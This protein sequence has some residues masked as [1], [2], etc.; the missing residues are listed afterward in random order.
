MVPVAQPG[1]LERL[2][3]SMREFSARPRTMTPA[4]LV[5]ASYSYRAACHLVK[6]IKSKWMVKT[7]DG[8]DK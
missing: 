5:T 3:L 8:D 2:E 1:S 6:S 7:L 4:E